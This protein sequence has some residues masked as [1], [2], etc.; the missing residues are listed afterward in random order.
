MWE[1]EHR[2]HIKLHKVLAQKR[3]TDEM[4]KTVSDADKVLGYGTA[5]PQSMT[6]K[7]KNSNRSWQFPP[8]A[9]NDPPMEYLPSP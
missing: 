4:R 3:Y 9:S 8:F 2:R 7:R 6:A 5:A 1:E